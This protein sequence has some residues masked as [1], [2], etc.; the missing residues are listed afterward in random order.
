MIK[1]RLLQY[2]SPM[3]RAA[4]EDWRKSLPIGAPRADLDHFLKL[5]A[6]S[7][8]W[9]YPDID[10][11]KSERYAGLTELRWKSGRKPHRIFGYESLP[12]STQCWSVA[13]TTRKSTTLRTPWKLLVGARAK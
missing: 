5:M 3:G 11:L 6:K 8:V 2:V 4:L 13:L 7:A 12:S 9:E 10:T 1:W